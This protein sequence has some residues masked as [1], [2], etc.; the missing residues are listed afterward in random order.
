MRPLPGDLDCNGGDAL[1]PGAAECHADEACFYCKRAVCVC[2]PR[3]DDGTANGYDSDGW[4][5]S[6]PR[7]PWPDGDP[8]ALTKCH[9][10]RVTR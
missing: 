3:L 2:D 5:A 1:A 8:E 7:L 4:E 6:P 10:W 9:G